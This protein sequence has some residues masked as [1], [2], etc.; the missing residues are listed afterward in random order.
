MFS[1][2]APFWSQFAAH[3]NEDG[4]LPHAERWVNQDVSDEHG[5]I[6][7]ME[8][9]W[10]YY[11]G[12]LDEWIG[13]QPGWQGEYKSYMLGASAVDGGS[14]YILKE[15]DDPALPYEVLIVKL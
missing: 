6:C 11:N 8:A 15:F 13:E 7:Y 12:A 9:A 5:V 10:E 3:L 4:Y 1:S 14:R 2:D